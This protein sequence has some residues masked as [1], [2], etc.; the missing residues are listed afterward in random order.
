MKNL[1]LIL[2]IASFS[3][4]VQ[5][6]IKTVE[7]DS[8]QLFYGLTAEKII[9]LSVS[10]GKALINQKDITVSQYFIARSKAKTYLSKQKIKRDS[11]ETMRIYDRI[12]KKLGMKKNDG[13]NK[14]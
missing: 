1:V 11:I 12:E 4:T 13:N 9:S 8:V 3:F 6:Q 10:Q 5:A 2:A 14:G 7:K